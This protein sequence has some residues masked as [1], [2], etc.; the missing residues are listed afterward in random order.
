M[1]EFGWNRSTCLLIDSDSYNLWGNWTDIIDKGVFMDGDAAPYAPISTSGKQSIFKS[2]QDCF[3]VAA[4]EG[5]HSHDL[6][7]WIGYAIGI[8][9]CSKAPNYSTRIE[10]HLGEHFPWEDLIRNPSDYLSRFLAE[11]G[12][13]G[14]LD[15]YP[16]PLSISMAMGMM[17]EPKL[18]D[19]VLEPCIGPGSI[20]LPLKSLNMVGMDLSLLMVKAACIHAFLYKPQLLFTPTP[21]LGIHVHPE[22]QRVHQYFEFLTDTRIYCG[23]SLLG[24]YYAPRKIFEQDSVF[25]D[26]YLH[27][28]RERHK[29][30]YKYR[31]ELKKEW[32]TLPKAL[33]F[34]IVQA[35]A[36]EHSF[37]VVLTNPPFN[38]KVSKFEKEALE[39]IEKDNIAFS[40]ELNGSRTYDLTQ[41]ALF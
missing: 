19:S 18:T 16:T 15:Y 12:S 9:W 1:R 2:L 41:L 35:M 32:S 5:H 29:E 30:I 17:M 4:R 22:E 3:D 40:A 13:S 38:V 23:N 14:H 24:E 7:D 28:V 6:I 31:K 8:A 37:D 33:R 11:N 34:K 25:E 26:I 36:R 10:E 20:I 39:E 27:P 21:I